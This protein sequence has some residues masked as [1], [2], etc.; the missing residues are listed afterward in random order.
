MKRNLL[1]CRGAWLAAL[2]CM[3]PANN[4]L[5][6]DGQPHEFTVIAV[7]DAGETGSALR[8]C[9][10]YAVDMYTG[11]HD[12][13]VFDAMIFLGDNFYNIGLNGPR[14]DADSKAKRVLDPFKEALR[15]LGKGNV[16]AI[17]GEHDYYARYLV[18]NSYLFGLI[19][20]ENMPAGLS[21]KGTLREAEI[22]DWTFH[23]RMPAQ[24]TFAM[25]PGSP[26]SIQFIFFDSALPLRTPPSTW[27]PALDSLR[28]ILIDSRNRTGIRWR[29]F[30]SHH[31]FFAVG[32]HAG[33]TVWD[34]ETN[35]VE[36][37]TRCD[38]DSNAGAW[39]E[40]SLDPEDLCAEKYRNS[41][42]SIRAVIHSAGV[43]LQ[44][45]LAAHDHSLQLL[46]YPARGADEAEF[47]GV[48]IISGAGSNPTQ[49]K[50]PSPPSEYTSAQT[51]PAKQGESCPG[52]VQLQFGRDKLRIRFFN[53]KTGD[54]QDMG[55]GRKEFW[56]DLNGTLLN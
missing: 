12:G 22:E 44:V 6:G 14:G 17:P 42:D 46:N 2:F 4:L 8:A 30:C 41:L 53:A 15:G 43:R 38:K 27:H 10:A 32:E 29:I 34:D 20:E 51:D 35:T 25:G 13:G 52:F 28:K 26:D 47:P 39:L 19:T 1:C 7:G 16:H 31:P 49:V 37:L 18:E 9:G 11:R 56:V 5:A 45:A 33:Y 3:L 36:Y 24:T 21:D 55:G 23:Y 48:Q 40:N 54:W 50:L